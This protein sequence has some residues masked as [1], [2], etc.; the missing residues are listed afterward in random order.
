M[1][2]LRVLVLFPLVCAAQTTPAAPLVRGVVLE[3]DAQ[4][5]SGQFSVRAPDNHV[6]RYQFDAK[7]IVDR[8]SQ[9]VEI[10]RLSPGDRV[11]VVSD[12]T[13]GAALRYART[14]HVLEEPP[15][16]AQNLG[17]LRPARTT[18]QGPS[19]SSADRL[20][21]IS[22]LT[23]SGTVSRVSPDRLVLRLR[24]G[25]D[26]TILLRKDTRYME[27]GE[28]A[29]LADLRPNMRVFVRAGKDVYQQAEAYQVVWGTLLGPK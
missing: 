29:N 23:Y 22:S 4:V 15:R 21:N 17:R 28:G 8:D 20:S 6:Y 19:I 5:E 9:A 7:T 2:S 26:Q 24:T 12:S 18:P 11:E 14:V 3:R 13:A 16:P 27:D 1:R 25:A 10:A